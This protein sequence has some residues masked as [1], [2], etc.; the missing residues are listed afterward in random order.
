MGMGWTMLAGST[1]TDNWGGIWAVTEEL[2]TFTDEAV[3]FSGTSHVC[4]VNPK[5]KTLNIFQRQAE[6][7]VIWNL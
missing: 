6:Q 3:S 2:V 5:S 7:W 4:R 1:G